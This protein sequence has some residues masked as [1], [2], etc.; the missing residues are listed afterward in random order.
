MPIAVRDGYVPISDEHNRSIG[1]HHGV[2]EHLVAVVI[3][4]RQLGLQYDN[5][6]TSFENNTTQY[7]MSN[8]AQTSCKRD[9]TNTC[10]PLRLNGNV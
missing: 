2:L 5:N 3:C 9:A 7:K 10:W 6:S 1:T 4:R 8:N